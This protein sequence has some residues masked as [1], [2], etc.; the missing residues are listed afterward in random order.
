[1][2]NPRVQTK[3][4]V[5]GV[6][7]LMCIANVNAAAEGVNAAPEGEAPTLDVPAWLGE[8]P[9]KVRENTLS[10]ARQLLGYVPCPVEQAYGVVLS[11]DAGYMRGVADGANDHILYNELFRKTNWTAV[12]SVFS[13]S[14]LSSK[15]KKTPFLY[16]E[17]DI[18]SEETEKGGWTTGGIRM[19]NGKI[20]IELKVQWEISE[21]DERDNV[22]DFIQ[23]VLDTVPAEQFET[24]EVIKND[25]TD[26]RDDLPDHIKILM[27]SM[28]PEPE[29]QMVKQYTFWK[30]LENINKAEHREEAME[31]TKKNFHMSGHSETIKHAI[32]VL[33]PQDMLNFIK[34]HNIISDGE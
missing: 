16:G 17:E 11:R 18:L 29:S 32:S 31:R 1:M 12:C 2:G 33:H 24:V 19:N 3:L 4:I 6:L 20:E 8:V 25:P 23:H 27:R 28:Q 22:T 10:M 14:E 30:S 5:S 7:F 34:E 26:I 21:S 9:E 13:S 15:P